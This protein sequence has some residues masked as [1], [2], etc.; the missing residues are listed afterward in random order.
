MVPKPGRTIHGHHRSYPFSTVP[1]VFVLSL[2]ETVRTVKRLLQTI[3]PNFPMPPVLVVMETNFAYGA[4]V[5]QAPEQCSSVWHPYMQMLW[6]IQQKQQRHRDLANVDIVF[7]TP[8]YLWD[9]T[10]DRHREEV[11]GQRL[12]V[13]DLREKLDQSRA[14]ML[15]AWEDKGPRRRGLNRIEI[16]NTVLKELRLQDE[17]TLD[18]LNNTGENVTTVVE[19]VMKA[20]RDRVGDVSG[21]RWDALS[22]FQQ[23]VIDFLTTKRRYYQE[24]KLL[25]DKEHQIRIPGRKQIWT[26]RSSPAG[27][28]KRGGP[29]PRETV[30]GPRMAPGAPRGHQQHHNP[31]RVSRH[32]LVGRT[33]IGHGTDDDAG[34][35]DPHVPALGPPDATNNPDRGSGARPHA[36]GAVER[37]GHRTSQRLCP[38]IVAGEPAS[39][40][41]TARS[42]A[43]GFWTECSNRLIPFARC[44]HPRLCFV[45]CLSSGVA[46]V[47]GWLRTVHTR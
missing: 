40:L 25:R 1:L 27:D 2:L 34:R 17:D 23:A 36:L 42:R 14:R 45:P 43:C 9:D 31:D 19:T 26:C 15:K 30:S 41:N 29:Q 18:P 10:I 37:N 6:F 4:T 24:H 13:Q 38:P 12:L 21:F 16:M 3:E 20:L 22:G 44:Q 47:F 39:H 7:A 8:V 35:K 32:V 46:F 11:R 28:G 5:P 33:Q